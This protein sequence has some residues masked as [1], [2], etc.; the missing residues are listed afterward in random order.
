[1]SQ[2]PQAGERLAIVKL[3]CL[4]FFILCLLVL[5]KAFTK[6]RWTPYDDSN[7]LQPA[8]RVIRVV[9]PWPKHWNQIRVSLNLKQGFLGILINIINQ[10]KIIKKYSFFIKVFENMFSAKLRRSVNALNAW[11][12]RPWYLVCCWHFEIRFSKW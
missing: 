2:S 3:R 10:G 4:F 5:S 6:L 11:R 9:Q 1:M 7:S 12:I 8:K